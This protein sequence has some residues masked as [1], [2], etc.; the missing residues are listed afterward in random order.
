MIGALPTGALVTFLISG[1]AV[2]VFGTRLARAADRLADVTGLGEAL[3][4]TLLLGAVT[5]LPGTVTSITAAAD[6]H[7]DLALSNALGGIAG[8]TAFLVLADVIYRDANLEHAAASLANLLAGVALIVL[9]SILLLTAT[10][11][12]VTAF[13]IHPTSLLLLVLY[14]GGVRLAASSRREPMWAPARTPDTREDVP[15]ARSRDA[16]VAG[17]LATTLVCGL[18]VAVAGAFIAR[19]GL[20]LAQATGVREGLVGVLATALVTSTPELVTTVAAVRR[21]ALTLAVGGILGGNT[22]DV[23][24]VAFSDAAYRDGSIYHRITSELRFVVLLCILM[25]ATLLLGLLRRERRGPGNVGWETA[26]LLVLYLT[27]MAAL[28]FAFG[29]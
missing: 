27:G 3:V 19:S 9:L 15:Q 28:V 26:A 20:A 2:L 18:V 8:Q 5:S 6:G 11:P 17:L 16:S 25:T 4:G 7:T 21:G 1:L 24:F 22:F 29:T 12:P 23:L 13:G 10:L 14:V